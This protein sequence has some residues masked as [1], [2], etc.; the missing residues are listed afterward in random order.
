ASGPLVRSSYK[1]AEVFL[2][3]LLEPGKPSAAA[4]FG[5]YEDLLVARLETARAAAARTAA[6]ARAKGGNGAE[7]P[8][9]SLTV[10]E[11]AAR[12]AITLL[13]AEEPQLITL[14]RKPA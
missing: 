8:S 4:A 3:S 1:A 11:L 9:E 6:A 10:S 2:R 14:R 7:N 12:A 5:S 13:G